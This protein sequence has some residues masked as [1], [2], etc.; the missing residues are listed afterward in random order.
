MR[1][2]AA[3]MVR[4]HEKNVVLGGALTIFPVAPSLTQAFARTIQTAIKRAE[5]DAYEQGKADAQMDMRRS[6]GIR[7]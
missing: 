3:R 2:S 5:E 6:L 7:T 4:A 1:N